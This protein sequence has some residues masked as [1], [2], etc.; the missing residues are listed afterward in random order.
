VKWRDK[1]YQFSPMISTAMSH[2]DRNRALKWNSYSLT[3]LVQPW[4]APHDR[5][6]LQLL[7]K[8]WL[9]T[10]SAFS[11]GFLGFCLRPNNLSTIWVIILDP[12]NFLCISFSIHQQQANQIAWKQFPTYFSSK[13]HPKNDHETTHDI[14]LTT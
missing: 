9:F 4:W 5:S 12:N 2:A 6:M 8:S 14:Q 10:F 3:C 7:T 11:D 1:N 13:Y